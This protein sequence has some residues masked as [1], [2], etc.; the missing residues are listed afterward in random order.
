MDYSQT[1]AGTDAFGV[2]GRPVSRKS[3]LVAFLLAFFLGMFGAHRFYA[4]KN[5]TAAAQL[6]LTCTLFGM[7]ISSPWVFIDWIV[8]LCGNFKDDEGR[9]ITHWDS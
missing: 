8:I 1:G 2:Y 5:G 3:R 4:G 6:I 7:L 9:K